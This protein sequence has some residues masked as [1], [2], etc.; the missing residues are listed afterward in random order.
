MALT[1]VSSTPSSGDV[2]V[3]I[4]KSISITFDLAINSQTLHQGTI[5]LI[6]T[7]TAIALLCSISISP[8]DPTTIILSPSVYLKENT[9][10]RIIAVGSDQALGTQLEASN[11]SLLETSVYIEFTTG[12]SIYNIDTTI[13]KD[14]ADKTLEGDLFLPSNLKALGYN[15]TLTKARPKNHSWNISPDITGDNTIR[16]SFSKPLLSGQDFDSWADINI[17]QTLNNNNY[18]ASGNS[19][20]SEYTIPNYQMGVVDN[21]FLIVFDSNLP[22]NASVFIELNK[23]ITAADGTEYPGMFDYT[24][25]TQTLPNISG[26]EVIKREIKPIAAAYNDDYIVALLFKN[27]IWLWEKLGRSMDI[28]AF[29]YAAN[30]YVIYSTILDLIEDADLS[31][32][33]K[34]GVRRRL[35]DF[36][37][38]VDTYLGKMAIKQAKYE[39]LKEI[40]FESLIKGWQFKVGTSSVAYDEAVADI[41][42]LWYNVN[43]RYTDATYKFYQEDIPGTNT[44]INRWAKTNNPWW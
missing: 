41:S 13:E 33:V 25:M 4:N 14:A 23:N 10:Y 8:T 22:K 43:N 34:A 9:L 6:D 19:L 1:L 5:N 42:R 32:W 39:K 37:V 30:Q 3:F 21:D 17:Y 27:A 44:T 38:E 29:P 31:K 36:S 20:S 16:F 12:E 28:N 35:G 15:F 11:G 2:D 24:F 18:F 40:A 7:S 26:P